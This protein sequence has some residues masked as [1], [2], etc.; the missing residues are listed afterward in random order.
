MLRNQELIQTLILADD[1]EDDR[2]IFRDVIEQI[3]P[4]IKVQI[5]SNG[6]SLIDLL[7]HYAPDLLFLDLEMPH[8]N[9][10]EC[11]SEMRA[12]PRLK[13]LPV[14]VFSSTTRP[15]NIQAAYDMGADLFL[16]KEASF[17]EY[18]SS[19][20]AILQLDW[21]D[22][23]KIKHQHLVNNRYVAFG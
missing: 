5:V 7:K 10:L 16:I 12:N 3:N 4:K 11:L 6:I 14:V 13:D 19:L 17:Q 1:D 22:R 18:T 23:L 2:D 15:A 20:K 21:K 9:G 8:K